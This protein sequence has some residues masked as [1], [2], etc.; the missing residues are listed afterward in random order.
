[1]SDRQRGAATYALDD[2]ERYQWQYTPGPRRGLALED[3]DD[4]QRRRVMALVDVGL[5]AGGARTARAVMRLEPILGKIEEDAGRPGSER[6]NRQHYWFVVFGD[7]AGN[8]P[9]GWRVGG[10]HLCLHFT[11]VGDRTSVTPLFVGANPARVPHGPHEGLRVLGP[12]EDLARDL[13][14]SFDE[15][16]CPRAIVS[17]RAPDDILTGNAVRAEIAAVPTGITWRSLD[18]DQQTLLGRLVDHHLG[19][20]ACPPPVDL[21]ELTFAWAGSSEPGEGHYYA[22]R[23]GTFLLEYD[24]T[25]N[26]ANHVHTVWRDLKRDWGEDLLTEHYLRSHPG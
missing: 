13:L 20:V 22:V 25:Q 15:S 7:P 18:P 5:S 19:R 24:N 10:H 6:R 12:E 1:L 4:A 9:W 14:A 11:V 17:A 23:G 8:Q 2:P 21:A 3:M 16:Q 26:H